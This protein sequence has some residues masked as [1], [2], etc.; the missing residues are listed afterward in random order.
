MEMFI[1]EMGDEEYS[2]RSFSSTKEFE[3]TYFNPN[4]KVS[5]VKTQVT[6]QHPLLEGISSETLNWLV[7]QN[8]SDELAFSAT[9]LSLTLSL[10]NLQVS[11][12]QPSQGA[13][14]TFLGLPYS[15]LMKEPRKIL[16]LI[17]DNS[18]SQFEAEIKNAVEKN[19]GQATLIF[20]NPG[21][22]LHLIKLNFKYSAGADILIELED[23]TSRLKPIFKKEQERREKVKTDLE[24]LQL[25]KEIHLVVFKLTSVKGKP[26]DW[27]KSLRKKLAE[28]NYLPAE[29]KTQVVL[30]KYEDDN[31][32][33]LDLIDPDIDDLV[34]LPLDRLIFLQKLDILLSLPEKPSPRFLYFQQVDLQIEISKITKIERLS[35]IGLAIRNPIPLKEGL[36]GHFFFTL[37]G[38][39]DNFDVFAKVIRS[40]PH[41]EMEK[42]YVVYFS[43]FGVSRTQ[44]TAI[45]QFLSKSS[46]YS[47]F[48][49]DDREAFRF[50]PDDVFLSE[51]E[52]RVR[53]VA[54]IEMDES[55]SQNMATSL[56]SDFDL[57]RSIPEGSM[58]LF[59]KK[60]MAQEI[61]SGPSEGEVTLA[62]K[63]DLHSDQLAFIL[64]KEN[65]D[66]KSFGVTVK[67][68][69]KFLGFDLGELGGS[70]Q[71]WRKPFDT[72]ENLLVFEDALKLASTGQ[73][74]EKRILAKNS[75]GG[76]RALTIQFSEK[77]SEHLKVRFKPAE[78]Q[79]I[80]IRFRT[81]QQLT[82]LDA[83][84]ANI[85]LV[86]G[87]TF[88][89]WLDGL[90]SIA[91]SKNLL[92]GGTSIKL[93]LTYDPNRPP[94]IR[95]YS[96][97]E[98]I[99]LLPRPIDNRLFLFLISQATGLKHSLY[100]FENMGWLSSLFPI[101]VAKPAKL[102]QI[103]EFGAAI[104]HP[105]PIV[106]G[107]VLFLRG[108][109]F[110]S[111]PNRNL[112]ARF[113][114]CEEDPS[115]ENGYFCSMLYYGIGDGFMK[116]ARA[117]FRE[118]YA[119]SKKE[120]SSS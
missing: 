115:G 107:T 74:I 61:A 83:I 40:D 75:E 35:D 71:A 39:K 63:E 117:W 110:D 14:A 17:S 87:E 118:T 11:Q 45:R 88:D 31:I 13:D 27:V 19:R 28:F 32:S 23:Q 103:G 65:F 30:T 120:E 54:I 108:G 64:S 72:E 60:Y 20:N 76:F 49:K 104:A 44:I 109:I 67:P 77:D 22:G 25:V 96:R 1:R 37:P 12:V 92:A 78:M 10:S 59:I 15:E 70:P 33:K 7:D 56:R 42:T 94:D 114:H 43:F 101:H 3:S 95:K 102:V 91:Q 82:S 29:G 106:P 55:I 93:I 80:A 111:A 66:F 41:P 113:Y 51:Q 73:T 48:V 98:V 62:S 116:H 24:S 52:K 105:R 34:Y 6:F 50:N 97:P 84:V 99:G 21:K 53:S 38:Q 36:I 68:E 89:S 100:H 85:D 26:I 57:I 46:N 119:A 86:P 81:E 58:S 47:S 9:R 2:V 90:N 5:E 16:S 4:L 112:C 69:E 8:L 79:D 18:I